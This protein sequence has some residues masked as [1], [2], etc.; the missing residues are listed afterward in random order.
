M[1]P[2][3]LLALTLA[4]VLDRATQYVAQFQRELSRVV[5]EERYHQDWTRLP[6]YAWWPDE[7][8]HRDLVSDLVLVRLGNGWMQFRDPR[9]VDGQP[10]TDRGESLLDVMRR[11]LPRATDVDALVDRSAAYNL[12]D[13]TRTVNT[14]LFALTFLEA[15]NLTR[16]RFTIA[17]DRVPATV[18][19]APDIP[20][21]FRTSTDVWVVEYVERQRP[22]LIRDRRVHGT[23]VPARG[24]FWIDPGTG[25]VF[26]SEIV[27]ENR[28]V[29]GT[30]DVSYQSEPVRGLLL[31][32]EMHEWYESR[33]TGS[34]IETVA[35]YGRF[36]DIQE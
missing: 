7:Q 22:T 20:G 2:V 18:S 30:I 24:R 35:T 23:D 34:K 5:A 14:P 17:P 3:V 8:R 16:C 26:M 19:V 33:K 12:G 36:R 15:A 29:R 21:V 25:R 11:G 31:P 13:V 28:D 4:T 9:V 32:V 10:V 27:A 6:K 1:T